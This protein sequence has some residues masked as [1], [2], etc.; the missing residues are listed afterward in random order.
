M[1]IT[2]YKLQ[3]VDRQMP[4]PG[5]WQLIPLTHDSIFFNKFYWNRVNVLKFCKLLQIGYIDKPKHIFKLGSKKCIIN[6]LADF[7][8]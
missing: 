4:V 2:E 8:R 3:Q 6:S 1:V 5:I 7:P